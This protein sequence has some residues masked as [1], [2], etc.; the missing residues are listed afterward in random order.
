VRRFVALSAA[1]FGYKSLAA[2]PDSGKIECIDD[3]GG[4]IGLACLLV[5]LFIFVAYESWV[6]QVGRRRA[7]RMA[8]YAHARMRSDWAAV[9]SERPGF[10]IVA[11]Q[12][13]R[14]SLM[15]ATIIASTAALGSMGTITLDG[16]TMRELP[17]M[18][19]GLV[20]VL[21]LFDRPAKSAESTARTS[22]RRVAGLQ[23][24]LA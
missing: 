24:T 15:S 11:V 10:E 6:L 3:A 23:A 17:F 2:W 5:S 1:K 13:L 19:L 20:F 7:Q 16:G 22:R 14:N 4:R 21:W 8:R 18:T 9:L 12:T